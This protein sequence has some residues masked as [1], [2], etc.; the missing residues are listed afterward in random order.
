[1]QMGRSQMVGSGDQTAQEDT[2]ETISLCRVRTGELI[3]PTLIFSQPVSYPFGIDTTGLRSNR[4][5][6][7][8]YPQLVTPGIGTGI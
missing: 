6:Y 4:G 7:L 2:K 1:M 3:N 8:P 5:Y